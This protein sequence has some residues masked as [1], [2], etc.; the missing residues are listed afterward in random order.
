[1][2]GINLL[3]ISE[4]EPANHQ[5]IR[6]LLEKID[7]FSES[8]KCLLVICMSTPNVFLQKF[9]IERKLKKI[10]EWFNYETTII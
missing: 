9:F 8:L 7:E 1:L 5:S 3:L 2:K 6:F 4:L 10:V